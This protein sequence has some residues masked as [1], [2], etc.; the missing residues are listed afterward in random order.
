ML[1]AAIVC[2][3]VYDSLRQDGQRLL[4]SHALNCRV[5]VDPTPSHCKHLTPNITEICIVLLFQAA[6]F[7]T[8]LLRRNGELEALLALAQ[9]DL[10]FTRAQV[11]AQSKQLI[12]Y[13]T[14]Y[15]ALE[16]RCDELFRESTANAALPKKL[17]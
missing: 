15:R 16:S 3:L 5:P 7:G 1:I 13:T 17:V 2:N 8:Q 4:H 6:E 12:D 14:K 9:D 11:Q 10:A